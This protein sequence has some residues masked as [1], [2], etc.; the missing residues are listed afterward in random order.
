M[1]LVGGLALAVGAY[2]IWPSTAPPS[3]VAELIATTESV[4][5]NEFR[6]VLPFRSASRT[7]LLGRVPKS[8]GSDRTDKDSPYLPISLEP[9][10]CFRVL[11]E[12]LGERF[13]RG[14]TSLVVEYAGSQKMNEEFSAVFADVGV[15]EKMEGS[16]RLH[17]EDLRVEQAEAGPPVPFGVCSTRGEET[18]FAIVTS[19]LVAGKARL[20]LRSE[21][22]IS[23]VADARA[24]QMKFGWKRASDQTLRADDV[25][26][27]VALSRRRVDSQIQTFELGTDPTEAEVE[28][29]QDGRKVG[30]V[31][32]TGAHLGRRV[33][34][35]RIDAPGL[36][37]RS[38]DG[39]PT[40]ETG[41][42]PAD[43]SCYLV[44]ASG[45]ALIGLSWS[46][47]P[48]TTPTRYR[49]EVD[50]TRMYRAAR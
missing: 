42:L 35:L 50:K 11:E 48:D 21:T 45:N 22:D 33:L 18:E 25:I 41:E 17:L 40:D 9:A 39:C 32:I 29:T 23:A 14:G 24:G 1:V 36:E 15:E 46:P 31:R 44:N 4:S 43:E 7:N 3:S 28:L 13:P 2:M 12:Q 34:E 47:V 20:E 26:L 5:G 10:Q 37:P 49:F 19:Q 30:D 16:A 38:T 6:V 8:Q 27:G